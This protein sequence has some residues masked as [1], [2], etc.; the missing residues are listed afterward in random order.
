MTEITWFCSALWE[1]LYTLDIRKL[2]LWNVGKS[3]TVMW[4]LW[5]MLRKKTLIPQKGFSTRHLANGCIKSLLYKAL[6]TLF[7][8]GHSATQAHAHTVMVESSHTRWYHRPSG[9]I[10][11]SYL[12]LFQHADR[13]RWEVAIPLAPQMITC[14]TYRATANKVGCGQRRFK[15]TGVSHC[16]SWFSSRVKRSA[17]L[18]P[19]SWSHSLQTGQQTL[20]PVHPA[21]RLKMNTDGWRGFFRARWSC[22]RAIIHRYQK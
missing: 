20:L 4:A 16:F 13:R 5:Q 11:G 8:V 12:R 2:L 21:W 7:F 17:V 10:L 14:S 6:H 18:R 3:Y 22:D 9:A 15:V 19:N 1:L